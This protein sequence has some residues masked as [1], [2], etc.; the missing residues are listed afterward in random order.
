MYFILWAA[1]RA[2]NT[3]PKWLISEW[4][5]KERGCLNKSMVILI[6]WELLGIKS[7]CIWSELQLPVK[8]SSII[9][10][11]RQTFWQQMFQ[12]SYFI[13]EIYRLL[14]SIPKNKKQ[15]RKHFMDNSSN[16]CVISKPNLLMNLICKCEF[17]T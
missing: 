9:A 8:N 5:W 11:C 2:L 16:F 15:S 12:E 13:W 10:S 1:V 14:Y 7:V 4:W 17:P 3:I 6:N